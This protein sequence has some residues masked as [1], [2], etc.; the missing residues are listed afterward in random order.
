MHE[1]DGQEA[2]VV[3]RLLSNLGANEFARIEHLF[4]RVDIRP[5][6]VLHHSRTPMEQVYFI[7]SGLVAVS[8]RSS[9]DRWVEVWLIGSEGMTG[10]PVVLGDHDQPPFRRVVLVGGGA[11]RISRHDLVVAMN[12]APRFRTSL[13]LYVH[14]ALLQSS[15]SSACNSAHPLKQRLC[16]LLLLARDCLESDAIPL[17]H[18]LLASLLCVRRSSVTETLAALHREALIENRR[19]MIAVTDVVGLQAAACE[20]WRVIHR[21][22]ERLR[23]RA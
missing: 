16:R 11:L 15:Q 1:R 9:R 4:H 12:D 20:C 14:F 23:G 3:N 18:R 13:L 2:A 10:I 5:R 7:E 8:A 19:G 6:Q 17:T 22:Y 21:E